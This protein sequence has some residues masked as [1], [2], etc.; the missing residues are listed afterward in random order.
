[1][2]DILLPIISALWIKVRKLLNSKLR[3]ICIL[4]L[5]GTRPGGAGWDW[6]SHVHRSRWLINSC[7]TMKTSPILQSLCMYVYVNLELTADDASEHCSV[8]KQSKILNFWK[9]F[10]NLSLLSL[11]LLFAFYL[12]AWRKTREN[13]ITWWST[14]WNWSKVAPTKTVRLAFRRTHREMVPFVLLAL[15]QT[16]QIRRHPITLG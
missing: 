11:L 2:L 10:P 6:L 14:F 12:S 3:S 1:M 15:R 13:W 8:F 4:A 16:R 7:S 9:C 5:C